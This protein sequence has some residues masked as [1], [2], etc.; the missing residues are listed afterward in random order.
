[1]PA[2][3]NGTQEKRVATLPV[4]SEVVSMLLQS[5]QVGFQQPKYPLSVQCAHARRTQTDYETLLPVHHS[6][7]IGDVF[8]NA[9]KVIF[10][11]HNQAARPLA[12]FW[13]TDGRIEAANRV[14][15]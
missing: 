11:A 10:K 8:F 3:V 12:A 15:H 2:G 4:G 9:A 1:M 5:P 14:F 13:L 6:L 7:R